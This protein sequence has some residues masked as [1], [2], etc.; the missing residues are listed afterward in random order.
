M[1]ADFSC[2]ARCSISVPPSRVSG[3]N[4][5]QAAFRGGVGIGRSGAD[6]VYRCFR[7]SRAACLE[8]NAERQSRPQAREAGKGVFLHTPSLSSSPSYCPLSAAGFCNSVGHTSDIRTPVARSDIRTAPACHIQ[9]REKK[10][11]T[12]RN[13]CSCGIVPPLPPSCFR[14]GISLY[15]RHLGIYQDISSHRISLP[16]RGCDLTQSCL[17]AAS[18]PPAHGFYST[19]RY[20]S[21][22]TR[23]SL[24]SAFMPKYYVNLRFSVAF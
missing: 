16:M 19:P 20:Y 18:A 1:A 9:G 13:H 5:P 21:G 22:N 2:F 3:P 10:S 6:A 24:L 11:A 12:N 17:C 8:D 23:F 15:G 14:V 4:L 7:A